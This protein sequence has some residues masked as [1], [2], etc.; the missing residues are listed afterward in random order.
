MTCL[1]PIRHDLKQGDALSQLLFKFALE[2]AIRRVQVNQDGL[3][4][5]CT[6]QF[7]VYADEVN[8][9]GGSLHPI[10]GMQKLWQRLV[11]RSKC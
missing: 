8:V 6:H 7:L 4:L 9:V 2:Y 11:R 5:N 10:K 3:Q 1:F